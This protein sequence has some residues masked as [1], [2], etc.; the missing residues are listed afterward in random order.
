M[1]ENGYR[2]G[3]KRMILSAKRFRPKAS[4]AVSLPSILGE[5]RRG[6]E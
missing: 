1:F 4:S 2:M 3:N 5:R 6:E